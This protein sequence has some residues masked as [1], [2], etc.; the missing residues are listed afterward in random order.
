MLH[1]KSAPSS[2]LNDGLDNPILPVRE[3]FS[4]SHTDPTKIGMKT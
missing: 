3:H 4:F 2:G 1:L